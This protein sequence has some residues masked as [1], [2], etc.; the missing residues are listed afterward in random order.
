M[1]PPRNLVLCVSTSKRATGLWWCKLVA[2][3]PEH[4]RTYAPQALSVRATGPCAGLPCPPGRVRAPPPLHYTKVALARLQQACSQRNVHTSYVAPCT[5]APCTRPTSHPARNSERTEPPRPGLAPGLWP[6]LNRCHPQTCCATER[7]PL[8]PVGAANGTRG[9]Q[10]HCCAR[11]DALPDFL[12][13]C[14]RPAPEPSDLSPLHL[15]R[16]AHLHLR[17]TMAPS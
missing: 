4:P 1:R 13:S 17:G 11:C 15:T 12:Q 7:L 9:G 8:K 2:A 5:H 10:S 16:R 14:R 3:H 6:N